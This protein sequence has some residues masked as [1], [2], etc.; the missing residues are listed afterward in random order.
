MLS[1]ENRLKNTAK[2]NNTQLFQVLLLDNSSNND[3]T[4]HETGKV[5]YFT[6][7]QHLNNGGSVF[8]TS[9]NSQKIATSKKR[10]CQN[11]NRARRRI[12]N[13]LLTNLRN[14]KSV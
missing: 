13:L 9:K 10:A 14:S 6:V 4:V 8:I 3:V 2:K 12:G 1:E 11:Y 5:N 7:K